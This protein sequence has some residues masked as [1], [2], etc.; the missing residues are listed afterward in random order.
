[1]ASSLLSTNSRGA[2]TC[3]QANPSKHAQPVYDP[4]SPTTPRYP[5]PPATPEGAPP[6]PQVRTSWPLRPYLS[7]P[8]SFRPTSACPLL[9]RPRALVSTRF[10]SVF[11]APSVHAANQSAAPP[12]EAV[13]AGR[14]SASRARLR[15]A[16][17]AG[18][19][20]PGSRVAAAAVVGLA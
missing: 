18:A 9:S 7:P 10:C 15:V 19:M 4:E 14:P 20:G 8:P 1:M 2:G 6:R 17:R 5:L 16:P 11:S 12:L 3:G 13:P